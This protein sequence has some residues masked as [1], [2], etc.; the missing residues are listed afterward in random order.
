MKMMVSGFTRFVKE[1]PRVTDVYMGVPSVCPCSRME[2]K[3]LMLKVH[4][5]HEI[6]PK[7]LST[8]L[9]KSQR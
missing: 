4:C 5:G 2:L 1:A 8:D 7:R 9:R 3:E 6:L